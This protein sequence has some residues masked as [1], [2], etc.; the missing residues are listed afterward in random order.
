M[1]SR[2]LYIILCLLLTTIS[3]AQYRFNNPIDITLEDGLP[4]NWVYDFEEDQYGF[5]WIGTYGG[6]CRYD[7]TNVLV[8]KKN[9]QDSTGLPGD[10]IRSLLRIGDTLWIGTYDG[11]AY[12]NLITGAIHDFPIKI[13]EAELTQDK[14]FSKAV[15]GMYKDRQGNIWMAPA[16]G[17]FLKVDPRTHATTRY[18]LDVSDQIP[19]VH[20]QM[21]QTSL[22]EITQDI[23]KDSI[24]WG[25]SNADLVKLNTQ[26]GKIDRL[27]Y[28]N[29]NS[30]LEYNLN[31]Y[32]CIYQHSDGNI[33]LGVRNRGLIIFN[34]VSGQYFVPFLDAPEGW[35]PELNAVNLR[36]ITPI[37]EKELYLTFSSG[38]YLY[39][40]E[41]KNVKP[42]KRNIT[43]SLQTQMYGIDFIDSGG[44]IWGAVDHGVRI[45]NPLTNQYDHFSLDH[46]NAS[47]IRLLPRDIMEDFYPGYI[48]I[49]GQ[50]TDGIYHI[51][52]VIGHSFKTPVS[53]T[54][55]QEYK[56]LHSW[57]FAQINENE[58][59]ISETRQLLY[60]K[61]GMKY[62]ESYA[63]QPN[64]EYES[65]VNM[66]LD[67]NKNLWIGSSRDNVWSL[68][69]HHKTI[70][71]RF[72]NL[73][74]GKFVNI[75]NDTK[76]NIWGV[77][78]QG[79]AVLPAGAQ[80]LKL[81]NVTQ[82]ANATFITGENFCEC[83]DGEIW[84]AGN[85][86]GL[87]L[88]SSKYPEKGIIKK[89]ILQDSVRMY[90]AFRVVCDRYNNLWVLDNDYLLKIN[91]K[92]WKITP[93]N[94]K[95][96][97]NNSDGLLKVLKNGN[98][99]VGTRG[100][101]YI[102]NPN[103][104]IINT[105]AP[106]PY[107]YNIKTNQGDKQMLAAYLQ[108]IPLQLRPKENTITIEFAAINFTLPQAT[109][110]RYRLLGADENWNDPGK[111]RAIT[112]SNLKGGNYT[113]QL[114]AANNEGIWSDKIYE[115]P[116]IIG[117]PWYKTTIFYIM[118][119]ALA[120]ALVYAIYRYRVNEIRRRRKIADRF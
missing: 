26:T 55:A 87:G 117:T 118:I 84:Q 19:E 71:K 103:E 116:I 56:Y 8:L 58:L 16:F 105:K 119:G 61:K 40:I 22:L 104:L 31:R 51:N 74:E 7:G 75:F 111:N 108:S 12:M 78:A 109:Q 62:L 68:N 39:N 97:I 25:I 90:I 27:R 64:Q 99:L 44:R 21:D 5:I 47:D 13:K 32:L 14:R 29:K 92:D 79:H 110:F 24:F 94:F 20:S 35:L 57:G 11:A 9:E 42:I 45:I 46:L 54:I 96:G 43:N 28:H 36:N 85:E 10:R 6:L 76:N 65:L 102:I 2:I 41:E 49:I 37:N 77:I 3:L 15:R 82:N 17:G 86:D 67:H 48:T 72:T 34:P 30:E 120:A 81:F 66:I 38:V 112:Y 4:H 60:Y 73:E 95:Y 18:A 107:V 98:L 1:K 91:K 93:Y 106:M 50:Y 115:L 52:P 88:L 83:P 33:Y 89:I 63:L 100:G 113:F 59:V 53:K 23:N 101:V 69:L 70:E 80:E 114:K